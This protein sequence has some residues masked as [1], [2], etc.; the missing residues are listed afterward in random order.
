MPISARV[1]FLN[2]PASGG[3]IDL[4]RRRGCVSIAQVPSGIPGSG[5]PNVPV[6][7]SQSP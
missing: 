7:P 6:A 1:R 3:G 4:A 5:G 2:A